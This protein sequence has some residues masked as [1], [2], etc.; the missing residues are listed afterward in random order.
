MAPN[1]MSMMMVYQKDFIL[2]AAISGIMANQATSPT[3]NIHF[4]NIAEDAYRIA[5]EVLKQE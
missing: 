1:G 2:C 5:D 4:K 3:T